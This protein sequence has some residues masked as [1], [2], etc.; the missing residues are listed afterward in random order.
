MIKT[1]IQMLAF[2]LI[3]VVSTSSA[4]ANEPWKGRTET[5]PLEVSALT[6][7]SLY[8]TQTAW[9]VLGSAAWMI[10]NHGFAD[11]IDNRVWVEGQLGPS[12]FSGG[13]TNAGQT[14]VQYSAHLRWDFTMNE[15]WTFYGL[16][17]LGGYVLPSYLGSTFT[18]HP[19]FGAGA[20]YQTKTALMFR[21]EISAEFIGAGV[22]VNF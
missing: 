16:G 20:E 13:S 14:G 15:Y 21:G 1:K 19:R 7:L 10:V 18:L 2:L 3:C 4:F 22:A 17:G 8:G 12:F 11:D 5:S 6:G 9:S